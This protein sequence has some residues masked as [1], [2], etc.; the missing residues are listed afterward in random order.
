MKK[1]KIVLFS[2][3]LAVGL[4]AYAAVTYSILTDDGCNKCKWNNKEQVVVCGKCGQDMPCSDLVSN[5]NG[6]AD[7]KYKHGK[8][9]NCTHTVIVRM[10]Y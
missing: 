4:T 7:Y 6:N 1:K 3:L 2:A 5:K 9:V 8:G 10:K